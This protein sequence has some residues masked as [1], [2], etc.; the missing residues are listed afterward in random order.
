MPGPARA[1]TDLS[2]AFASRCRSRSGARRSP[3]ATGLAALEGMFGIILHYLDE[4]Q[5][6]LDAGGTPSPQIDGFAERIQRAFRAPPPLTEAQRHVAR[7][8]ALKFSLLPHLGTPG[9]P[10]RNR[11][12]CAPPRRGRGRTRRSSSSPIV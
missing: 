12:C 5:D 2:S 1:E 6:T 4:L 7:D 11:S 10:V 3:A 8:L 9:F